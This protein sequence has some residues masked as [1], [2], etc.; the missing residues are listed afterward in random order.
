MA[1][2]MFDMLK[3]AQDMQKQMQ[4]V[5]AELAAATFKGTAGGGL[6]EVEVSGAHEVKSVR[7]KPEAVDP[8][9]VATLEDLV[10]VAV[11]SA[12]AMANAQAE[13][14]MGAITGGLKLPGM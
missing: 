12:I 11:S 5:Q 9:D 4:K 7:I 2:G 14:R 13:S 6:V 1:G 8:A 3:K 10:R